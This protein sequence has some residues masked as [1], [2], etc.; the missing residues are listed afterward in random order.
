M[1]KWTWERQAQLRKLWFDGEKAEYIA[2]VLGIRPSTLRY[3]QARFNLPNRRMCV[4][5]ASRCEPPP[6]LDASDQRRAMHLWESGC[7]T[8]QIAY[9]L[10]RSEAAVYNS[11]SLHKDTMREVRNV[12]TLAGGQGGKST[13]IAQ[14]GAV[15]Q[16]DK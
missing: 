8:S 7:D 12:R 3:A 2:Y 14:Q 1:A 6:P 4:P 5:P 10:D 15:L 9:L 16:G 13:G 11:I